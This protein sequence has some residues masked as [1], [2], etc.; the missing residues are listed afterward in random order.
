MSMTVIE[1]SFEN[2]DWVRHM[3]ST[4]PAT[5]NVIGQVLF[6]DYEVVKVKW[7]DGQVGNYNTDELVRAFWV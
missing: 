6:T 2:G 5:D 3:Y 7:D 4:Y 1:D